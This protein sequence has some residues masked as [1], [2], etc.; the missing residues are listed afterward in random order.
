MSKKLQVFISSTF[1]D[2]KQERQ[3]AVAAVLKSGHIPAGMELFTSGDQSQLDTI[4]AWIDESDVYML[5]LGGRY[6]TVET[7]SGK[8]YTE[9][10]FDY[11]VSKSKPLFSVVINE[12]ALEAK[13]K[14]HGT[15]VIEST[16]GLLLKKFRKKV[17]SYVS[18]F[19]DDQKDIRLT[20]YESL[21][22]FAANKELIGWVRGNT[23]IDTLPLFDEIKKLSEENNNLRS[24][25]TEI[26][27]QQKN[28]GLANEEIESIIS[29]LSREIMNV[30]GHVFSDGKPMK[31]SALNLFLII[32]T[33]FATGIE[34]DNQ[35][36]RTENFLFFNLAPQLQI[37]GL[38]DYEKVAGARYRRCALTSKGANF[39]SS[40]ARQS[41]EKIIDNLAI[42]K[43]EAAPLMNPDQTGKSRARPRKAAGAGK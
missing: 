1:V 8:S 25:V 34:N 7:K 18:S 22:D 40:L 37:L 31:L 42:E 27:R 28:G 23:V 6:G 20:V 15:S 11:A 38:V 41:T 32:K 30:P 35:M 4:K 14:E 24:K 16:N 2:L 26:T 17:L 10:E 3:A 29:I 21:A 43:D 36:T 12:N 19:Y 13:V 33:A 39:L 9:L 5:I